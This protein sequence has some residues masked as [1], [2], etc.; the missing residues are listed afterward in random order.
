MTEPCD[1]RFRVLWALRAIFDVASDYPAW[2]IGCP[3][4]TA[5]CVTQTEGTRAHRIQVYKR[6]IA[7]TLTHAAPR[8]LAPNSMF[9]R[10]PYA[11][12]SRKLVLALDV[13]T[14]FSGVSYCILDPGEIPKIH[15]VSK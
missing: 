1:S 4:P 5:S 9:A 10:E 14:T 15:G 7:F 13:G 6:D 2:A 12:S 8:L 11:G 3:L